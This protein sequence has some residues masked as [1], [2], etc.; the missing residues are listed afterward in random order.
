MGAY[1][2]STMALQSMLQGH[3]DDAADMALSAYE[4]AKGH[5]VQTP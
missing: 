1:V 3:P 5:A 2:L 4:R